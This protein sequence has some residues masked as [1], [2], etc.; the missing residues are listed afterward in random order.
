MP[1]T[2]ASSHF[3]ISV[4][5][6][7]QAAPV[8]LAT[9]IHNGTNADKFVAKAPLRF[10]ALEHYG[11]RDRVI[12][13]MTDFGDGVSDGTSTQEAVDNIM[14]SLDYMRNQQHG[15]GI[16][17]KIK[18]FFTR[19]FHWLTGKTR[20]VAGLELEPWAN[21]IRRARTANIDNFSD[22]NLGNTDYAA[23]SL[24]RIGGR[25][26]HNNIIVYVV[27]PGVGMFMD[28]DHDRTILV[29][30]DHGSYIGANN[31]ALSLLYRRLIAEG[32]EPK[33]YQINFDTVQKL[34]RLRKN[35]PNYRIPITFHGRDVFAVVAGLMA[36]GVKPEALATQ[37]NGVAKLVQPVISE[38]SEPARLPDKPGEIVSV[39]TVRDKTLG[40]LKLNLPMTDTDYD[41]LLAS[42]RNFQVRHEGQTDWIDV[43]AGRTFRDVKP[44]E[45]I[46][47][48]GSSAGVYPGSRNVEIAINLGYAGNALKVGPGKSEKLQIRVRPENEMSSKPAEQQ[49]KTEDN[50]VQEILRT[51]TGEL[52]KLASGK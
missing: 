42:G 10:G 16:V 33:L 29:T 50:P 2:L 34:E 41:A 6:A 15:K 22:I 8:I 31:G 1:V 28:G 20:V 51:I 9:P 14:R 49:A 13:V 36:A 5:R 12:K 25:E 40:N 27:D 45:W 11:P 7:S 23:L 35:D 17:G 18:N 19:L 38:F 3:P 30:K 43:K 26:K 44:G 21:K 4:Q 46:L 48:H 37:E 47:Y 32:E 24:L 52:E 39:P